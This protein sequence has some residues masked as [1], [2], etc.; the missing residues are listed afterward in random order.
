MSKLIL[1]HGFGS[2]DAQNYRRTSEKL[3]ELKRLSPLTGTCTEPIGQQKET[4]EKAAVVLP[5]LGSKIYAEGNSGSPKQQCTV[6]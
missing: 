2:E 1:Q 5:L 3:V 4:S 6:S